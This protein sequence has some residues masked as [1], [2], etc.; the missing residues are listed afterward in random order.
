MEIERLVAGGVSGTLATTAM[1]GWMAAGRLSGR[2]GE[3]PPKRLV[4]VISRRMGLPARRSG[5]GTWLASGA[6]HL[7]FGA[8]CG[9]LYSALTRRSTTERGIAFGLV[10]W[11]VSYAGWV[12]ALSL[13]PPPQR[14]DP[15]RAWTMLTAHVVYGAVLGGTLARLRRP[16][17]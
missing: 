1:T 11:A 8:G 6:A 12:P 7:G 17:P 15:R 14:D 10:V 4:R 3:P 13:M 2:H 9:A 16:A 5:T